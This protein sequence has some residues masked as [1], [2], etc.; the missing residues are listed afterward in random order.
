M[1]IK[2]N[3]DLALSHIKSARTVSSSSEDKLKF[4]S[5]FKQV[6]NGDN[7]APAPSSFNVIAYAKWKAWKELEGTSKAKAME[8][9]IAHLER[10][11]PSFKLPKISEPSNIPEV[12]KEVPTVSKTPVEDTPAPGPSSFLL[13]LIG[14][15]TL[16]M[17]GLGG[18]LYT[19][20]PYQAQLF[21]GLVGAGIV[22]IFGVFAFQLEQHGLIALFPRLLKRILLEKSLLQVI[23]EGELVRYYKDNFAEILPLLLARTDKERNEA[24]ANMDIE[25]RKRLTTK[26]VVNTLSDWK[27]RLLLSRDMYDSLEARGVKY[28]PPLPDVPVAAAQLST[29]VS[30]VKEIPLQTRDLQAQRKL[31]EELMRKIL[32][33]YN[34]NLVLKNVNPRACKALAIGLVVSLILQLR[35]SSKTRAAA[36][37][38]LRVLIVLG[39][40]VGVSLAVGLSTLHRMARKYDYLEQA[41]NPRK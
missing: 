26:G 27:K 14:C 30:S 15:F 38:V 10:V 25:T 5:L 39:S 24:L 41:E 12:S 35:L 7:T 8:M 19:V 16:I 18:F 28:E 4:Y 21:L 13:S 11:D 22:G 17:F 3:F 9:Y 37:S 36:A 40:G 20:L 2:D 23:K 6:K 1:A 29:G 32:K 33:D 34:V 31:S